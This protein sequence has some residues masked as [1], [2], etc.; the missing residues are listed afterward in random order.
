MYGA[1]EIYQSY[2]R[3]KHLKHIPA[4]ERAVSF[5]LRCLTQGEM[6]GCVD[7]MCDTDIVS[8]HLGSIDVVS[9]ALWDSANEVV[10]GNKLAG[11]G[12]RQMFRPEQESVTLMK[13]IVRKFWRPDDLMLDAFA[14]TLF[15]AKVCL[16]L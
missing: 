13:E 9:N 10:Y 6:L 8:P 2:L 4:P 11:N 7:D 16:F 14:E 15:T 5:Q 1:L 3:V 12:R